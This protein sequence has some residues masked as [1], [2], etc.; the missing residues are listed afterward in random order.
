VKIYKYIIYALLID[1][2]FKDILTGYP[3][4]T[5]IHVRFIDDILLGMLYL[6]FIY[7]CIV[8]QKLDRWLLM[9]CILY[10]LF[11]IYSVVQSFF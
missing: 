4:H 7:Y 1:V 3:F 5:S 6:G 9:L 8:S 11:G 10:F 2:I